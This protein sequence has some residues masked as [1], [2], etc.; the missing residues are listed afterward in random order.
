MAHNKVFGGKISKWM[1][2]YPRGH[3]QISTTSSNVFPTIFFSIKKCCSGRLF[4][5]GGKAPSIQATSSYKSPPQVPLVTKISS[6]LRRL[7]KCEQLSA[8]DNMKHRHTDLAWILSRFKNLKNTEVKKK[9]E[10]FFL[11]FITIPASMAIEQSLE[12]QTLSLWGK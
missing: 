4:P 6:T 11:P 5:S 10:F 3:R 1:N 12:M 2:E 8:G 9:K 7:T